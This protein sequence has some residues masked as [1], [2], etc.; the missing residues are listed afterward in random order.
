MNTKEF[1]ELIDKTRSASGGDSDRHAEML[2][3]ELIKLSESDILDYQEI[4]DDLENEAYIGELWAVAYL[5]SYGCGDDD[6]MDFRAWLIG[7]GKDVFDGA[8]ADPESLVDFV[9]V[10]QKITAEPLLYVALE[11]YELKTGRSAEIWPRKRHFKSN[12]ELLK[13]TLIID[14]DLRL[15]CFPKATAK[16]WVWWQNNKDKWFLS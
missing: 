10:G 14:R 8:I 16:F 2:V 11:A 9:E 15:K 12:P 3:A 4:L 13:G 7:Q 6:F 1:W 5:I